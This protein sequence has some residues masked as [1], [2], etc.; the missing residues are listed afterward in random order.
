MATAEEL[1]KLA[2]LIR[3]SMLA[4]NHTRRAYRTDITSDQEDDVLRR[5]F[6]S[7]A[8]EY[9]PE[10]AEQLTNLFDSGSL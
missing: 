7:Y 2:R 4:L 8:Q 6:R 10:Q 5:A 1:L 3:Q 9:Y